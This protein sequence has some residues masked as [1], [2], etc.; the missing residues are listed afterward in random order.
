MCVWYQFSSRLLPVQVCWSQS[1]SRPSF[2]HSTIHSGDILLLQS[3]RWV[4]G[5]CS[6]GPWCGC[7][8]QGTVGPCWSCKSEVTQ[9][10]VEQNGENST[11][12]DTA[13]N[14]ALEPPTAFGTTWCSASGTYFLR[15]WL[16]S[17]RC[18]ARHIIFGTAQNKFPPRRGASIAKLGPLLGCKMLQVC[19]GIY[20]YLTRT[21]AILGIGWH[22]QMC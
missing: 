9:C 15:D 8:L 4:R 12:S 22:T 18:H 5:I 3:V 6:F 2:I 7:P 17:L 19:T 13:D 14:C 20:K 11:D 16:S 10:E 1:R 21:S